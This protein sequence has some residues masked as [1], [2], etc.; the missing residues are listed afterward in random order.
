MQRGGYEMEVE[1]KPFG[2]HSNGRVV[3]LYTL[4]NVNG[5]QATITNYGGILVSL[6]VPD[7]QGESADVVLGFDRL[8]G[9]LKGHPYFGALVGRYAN[10]IAN[11]RFSLDG[12]EY[13]LAQN[14]DK[15]HLHGG[16]V[17]YDKVLWKAQ[18]LHEVDRVGLE[19]RHSSPDGDEGYPGKLDMTVRYWLTNA[20]EL[21]IEYEA[22]TDK[23]T[24][25]NLTHHSYFNLSGAGEGDILDHV[26][27]LNAKRYTPVDEGM[28][29]TG[30]VAKV[31][32]TPLDFTTPAAIGE[33]INSDHEQ[34]L[35]G[36]G[37]DHNW[38][39]DGPADTVR[40]AAHVYDPK[41]GRVM[42]VLTSEPAIQF[43]TGN[44]LDGSN[45][46]KGGK[47]YHHRYGFCLEAQHYPD[48]PNHADFPSTILRPNETY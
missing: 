24:P 45:T 2:R 46:G 5:L 37:Y 22:T 36:K 44:F 4:T 23:A 6:M 11:G 26:L 13:K 40:L 7:R 47:V 32:G 15:N 31:K 17:G 9:Y 30:E 34:L 38:V 20:N 10:R 12:V 8:E 25:V 16:L 41:S 48:S 43:Y 42:E 19:L 28:I 14:N 3:D 39:V 21:Q 18:R 35:F 1:K 27:R 29:P 33:R